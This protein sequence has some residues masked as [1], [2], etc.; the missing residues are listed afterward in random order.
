MKMGFIPLET[1][2]TKQ[3]FIPLTQTE[4]KGFIPL[5]PSFF[6]KAKETVSTFT[7][8]VG[9]GYKQ[10]FGS[11]L[12]K[13]KETMG[14]AKDVWQEGYQKVFSPTQTDV[15]YE[16]TIPAFSKEWLTEQVPKDVSRL[17]AGLASMPYQIAEVDLELKQGNPQKA[18]EMIKGF[19]EFTGNP[20]GLYDLARAWYEEG[21][22]L[23]K[24]WKNFK[25]AWKVRPIQSIL[26]ILPVV[27]KAYRAPSELAGGVKKGMVEPKVKELL[28]DDFI[29]R[30]T[31]DSYEKSPFTK[32]SQ[33][34]E[35]FAKNYV[36]DKESLEVKK[37]AEKETELIK[38]EK[39]LEKQIGE[40]DLAEFYTKDKDGN[41]IFKPKLES[42]QVNSIGIKKGVPALPPQP[43]STLIEEQ[44]MQKPIA[45]YK[46]ENVDIKKLEP[47]IVAW[48]PDKIKDIEAEG[49]SSIYKPLIVDK[50]TGKILDGNQRTLINKI[51]E[52]PIT[53]PSAEIKGFTPLEEATQGA[54]TAETLK[55]QQEIPVE[56]GGQ[57]AGSLAFGQELPKYAGGKTSINLERI[58]APYVVKKTINDIADAYNQ[59]KT[60]RTWDEIQVEADSIGLNIKDAI[61]DKPKNM[62][63]EAWVKAKVDI[64]ADSATR[65][66]ALQ[67]SYAG[68]SLTEVDRAA[69]RL[70]MNQH[71]G[72]Q[73]E[74]LGLATEAGRTLNIHRKLSK[75]KG[76]V[77][78]YKQI[79]DALGGKELNKEIVE[80]FLS[81]D[82]NNPLAIAKFAREVSKAKTSSM[83]Y[84]AWINAILSN[85]ATHA[86]NLTG[87]TLTFLS[88]PLLE[89]PLIA[90]IEA[91]RALLTGKPR[92]RFYGEIPKELKGMLQPFGRAGKAAV[93]EFI[94]SKQFGIWQGIKD[95][96][97]AGLK[98][99]EL[100]LPADIVLAGKIEQVQQQAI[101]GKVGSVVRVPGTLLKAA[102]NVFKAVVYRAELNADAYRI[103]VREG[104]KGS[105]RAERITELINNPT[106]SMKAN[107]G[108]EA[109]YRTFNNP[110]AIASWIIKSQTLPIIGTPL[111][112]IVPFKR[113]PA[114][115]ASFALERTP[116]ALI[117]ALKKTGIERREALAKIG[118]GTILGITAMQFVTEG[119]I[120]GGGPKD[121]N[122][123]DALYRT[124][125]QPYSLKI[126]DKYYS[127]SRLEPLGSII[128]MATD[129][130][131]LIDEGTN[132][133][134]INELAGQ[135]ALSFTKNITSKTFMSGFVNAMDAISDP[136]RYGEKWINQLTGSVIPSGVGG[137]AREIDPKLRRTETPLDVIKSKIPLVSESLLPKRDLWGK[138]IERESSG[139]ISPIGISTDK[140]SKVD[141]EI[142]RL[143]L[144]IGMPSK[145]TRGIELTPEE[146]DKY[147]E[148]AGKPA[149][150]Q[151]DKIVNSPLWE[152]RHDEAKARIIESIINVFRQKAAI[153]LYKDIDKK[154]K[155]EGIKKT[156]FKTESGRE[157]LNGYND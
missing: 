128:G 16:K 61:K 42:T 125:W 32:E 151:L 51:N 129:M 79:L 118:V 108:K 17:A 57:Q 122:K 18:A 53:K 1:T 132:K 75:A 109:L 29:D 70:V 78:G 41:L 93:S 12:G 101:P 87:N 85:P 88:K 50:N 106:D 139:F 126:G 136:Q 142:V 154:R 90:T 155:I 104:L 35:T 146:H 13:V 72:I 120:T 99:F 116:L 157:T 134:T 65:L 91:G 37:Q 114:N 15:E 121:K 113:T 149:K 55:G 150:E 145:T 123:R 115:I 92:E 117:H 69:I 135:I 127:Y 133:K 14:E 36:K 38:I 68:K 5:E 110:N 45:G 107:A 2:E 119:L 77:E 9:E 34:L 10:M 143:K 58:D 48:I 82:P 141:N 96:V 31:Y 64:L 130:K 76:T 4:T 21:T 103:A 147:I 89:T 83:V 19:I 28:K 49:V 111:Q 52:S 27:T 46:V 6:D 144:N 71:A 43:V 73:A 98:S 131:E 138:P 40:K 47:N 33:Q 81:L 44:L 156:R 54:K 59:Q 23:P 39:E 137:A 94:K 26:G 124:G 148:L 140:M 67:E 66:R 153:T 11:S 80:R 25:E 60:K 63:Q 86:V 8:D 95:G 152:G 30:E 7:G 102:D 20:L 74:V 84:E 97:R 3:G 62:S 22:L 112:Y 100:E 105:V 56:I 24:E